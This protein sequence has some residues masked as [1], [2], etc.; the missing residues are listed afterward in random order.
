MV[1]SVLHWE[2]ITALTVSILKL[3]P[4]TEQYLCLLGKINGTVFSALGYFGSEKDFSA[5]EGDVI[6]KQLTTL[7]KPHTAIK[8]LGY[9]TNTLD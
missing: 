2:E 6:H 3:N 5:M 7:P 4:S 8:H 9:G 1:S